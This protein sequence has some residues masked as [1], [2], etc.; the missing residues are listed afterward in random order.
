MGFPKTLLI[1]NQSEIPL[2]QWNSFL[3]AQWP[4]WRFSLIW[5][6]IHSRNI[7]YNQPPSPIFKENVLKFQFKYL[8]CILFPPILNYQCPFHK[9]CSKGLPILIFQVTNHFRQKYPSSCPKLQVFFPFGDTN[10]LFHTTDKDNSL[11]AES[12]HTLLLRKLWGFLVF[13]F[14]SCK[15][16]DLTTAVIQ[17][18][19]FNYHTVLW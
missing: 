4:F 12:P 7:K 2:N 1:A 6:P 5:N 18:N 10:T 9:T 14:S 8:R 19:S 3:T 11:F 16:R 17:K 15:L 13:W